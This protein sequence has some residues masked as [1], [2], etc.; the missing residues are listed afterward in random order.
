MKLDRYKVHEIEIVVDR[1]K[2]D[3]NADGQKRLNDSIKTAMYHGDDVLMVLEQDSGEVRYFSRNL[4]CPT[5][6]ISY[7]NPEPNNFSFNSPK[8][9]C[10]TCNGIGALHQVNPDKLI[11]DKSKSIKKRSTCTSWP[12]KKELGILTAGI[13]C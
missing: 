10:P 13:N 6:G 9:A 1:L 12:T 8:G 3:A 11:P 2:I 5:T 7:P 4:M